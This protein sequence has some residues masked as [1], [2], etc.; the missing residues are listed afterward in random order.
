MCPQRDT[1]REALP[2]A[3]PGQAGS[4]P[5]PQPCPSRAVPGD[6]HT[7]L[8]GPHSLPGEAPKVSHHVSFQPLPIALSSFCTPL[9]GFAPPGQ[10]LTTLRVC[11]RT[12]F[13]IFPRQ[14]LW[15]ASS[16]GGT[17]QDEPGERQEEV[18]KGDARHKHPW[19]KALLFVRTAVEKQG[20]RAAGST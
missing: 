9:D 7:A 5:S 3:P 2:P 18:G 13:L 19:E 12:D 6:T 8:Q 14:K 17:C 10:P 15:G 20:E 16:S 4:V 1:H 11:G